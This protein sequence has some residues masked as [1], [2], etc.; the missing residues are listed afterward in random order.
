[1]PDMGTDQDTPPRVQVPV[2]QGRRWGWL[3]AGVW[4][5]YLAYPVADLLG[6]DQPVWL[7]ATGLAGTVLF[8][9]GYVWTIRCGFA[10]AHGASG[11]LWWL[12]ALGLLVLALLM[13]PVVGV[14]SATYVVFAVTTVVLA[15]PPAASIPTAVA[16]VAWASYVLPWLVGEPPAAELAVIV[17]V[18]AALMF[19]VRRMQRQEA[20]LKRAH[21]DLAKLAVDAERARFSRDLHDIVGHSLT[22]IIMKAELAGALA[23]RRPAAVGTEVADIE[24]LARESLEDV[25]RTVAGY[26]EVTLAGELASARAVL[27][28]AG[29]GATLPPAVDEVPGELRELFGWVVRE[30]VTNVVR[31]SRATHCEVRVTP[32]SVVVAD[33]GH[34]AGTTP[35]HGLGGLRERVDAAGGTLTAGPAE[36]GGFRL[37]VTVPQPARDVVAP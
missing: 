24:R 4:L 17:A 10:Q 18:V 28:A 2:R 29:I 34:G 27:D 31:H 6:G 15:W 19:A 22:A 23:E 7:R 14:G 32:S 36:D 8:A 16:A 3:L 35:G 20:T 25:R 13:A 5:L 30:G 9:V 12:R 1:M 26:R 37:A 33:N 21:E 11:R